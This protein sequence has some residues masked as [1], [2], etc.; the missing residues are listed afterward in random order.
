MLKMITLLYSHNSIA[1]YLQK[2]HLSCSVYTNVLSVFQLGIQEIFSANAN[3]T[4]IVQWGT[5]DLHISNIFHKA[6]IEINEEG[7]VAA[8]ATGKLSM[9]STQL[10]I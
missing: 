8:A 2:T 7:T 1:I 5:Q 6:K 9:Y 10:V 4:G 3:L